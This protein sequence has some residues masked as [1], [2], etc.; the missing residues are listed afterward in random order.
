MM[1]LWTLRRIDT[2]I[3]SRNSKYN[4]VFQVTNTKSNVDLK[5]CPYVKESRISIVLYKMEVNC[6]IHCDV[7][8]CD[9]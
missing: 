5:L 8:M 4:F 7:S 1:W 9:I 6:T 3:L 2:K